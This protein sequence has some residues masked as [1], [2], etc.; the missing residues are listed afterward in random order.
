[1]KLKHLHIGNFGHFVDRDIALSAAPLQIIYGPNEAG[2]TTLL[3][4]LRGWLF[5]FPAR[6]PYDFKAGSEIA[7]VGTLAF[8][9][10]RVVELRRRKG[11]KNKVS[12]K[13]D[14]CETDLDETGFAGLIGHANRNLFESVFAFG[15]DQLSQG[16]E[17]LKHESLQSALF[18]GGLGSAANPEK[19]DR[20][21]DEQAAELFSPT[22]RKPAIN[23]LLTEMK[24]LSSQIKAKSLRSG[25]YQTAGEAV[26]AA[27]ARAAELEEQVSQL[28]RDYR[29]SRKLARAL[30]K[31][32]ELRQQVERRATLSIPPGLPADCAATFQR[33]RRAV[34]RS[35]CSASAVGRRY[36]TRRARAGGP[37]IE[38]AIGLTVGRDQNRAWN[39]GN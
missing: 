22:A 2:K 10:G 20:R 21:L 31:W 9:D 29:A 6:T 37:A 17:S 16:E 34:G 36:R 15:L 7:G 23:Q 18:S 12:V 33:D 1:M 30:P 14:C 25:D 8:A 35:R 19:I 38:S 32:R 4:F 13:I 39:C 3:Q 27:D 24:D 28:R 11:T 5:D 26:A